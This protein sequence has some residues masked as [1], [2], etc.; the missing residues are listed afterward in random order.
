MNIVDLLTPRRVVCIGS[1]DNKE[2]LLELLGS[3]LVTDQSAVTDREQQFPVILE[4]FLTK[5]NTHFK[6]LLKGN[7]KIPHIIRYLTPNRESLAREITKSL[8][9]RERVISTGIGHGVALPH[10]RLGQGTQSVG[11]F[12]R[13]KQGVDFDALDSQPVDL[14]FGLLVPKQFTNKHLEILALLAEMFSDEVFCQQL[15]LADTA[16]A[17]FERLT[18]WQP[19]LT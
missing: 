18:Q 5:I 14:V 15:R 3:L 4:K 11:A 8:S 7:K 9:E 19:V 13:L 2:H 1:A 6:M 10:V 16:Q 17:L 12:I